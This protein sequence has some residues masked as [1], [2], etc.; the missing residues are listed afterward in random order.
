MDSSGYTTLTRQV[1]LM[2]EMQLVANNI[3]NAST[4]GFRREG[5]VFSEHIK[6]LEEGPSLSM[7]NGNVRHIDMTQ[8]GLSQTEGTFD[9]AIQG[10]GF[11]QIDPQLSLY[12]IKD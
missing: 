1:G 4:T 11:F 5:M 8:A 12:S 3:A 6:R 9:F 2:R 10:D 7:A